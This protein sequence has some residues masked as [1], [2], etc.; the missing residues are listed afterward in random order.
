MKPSARLVVP[1]M[2]GAAR[3]P[4]DYTVTAEHRQLGELEVHLVNISHQGFM[5]RGGPEMERGERLV[6]RLP[7][8]GR[9]EGH[10]VWSHDDRAGYQFERIIRAD[11]FA[12]LVVQM[13]PDRER[14]RGMRRADA[15]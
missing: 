11:D 7:V 1:E 12:K 2:R 15:P 13:Q 9:I 10:L 3:H 6:F 5:V 4:I 8:I 14:R